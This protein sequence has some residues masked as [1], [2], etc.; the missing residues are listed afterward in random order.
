MEKKVQNIKSTNP[1]NES[2]NKQDTA[3]ILFLSIL[4]LFFWT[5]FG[6]LFLFIFFLP[7]WVTNWSIRSFIKIKQNRKVTGII[8]LIL[9]LLPPMISF[10]FILIYKTEILTFLKETFFQWGSFNLTLVFPL[11]EILLWSWIFFIP[12]ILVWF[13]IDWFISKQWIKITDEWKTNK[14][15]GI[16]N[17]STNW[18]NLVN[19]LKWFTVIDNLKKYE[20][21]KKN[22]NNINTNYFLGNEAINKLPVF[23]E[24][25]KMKQHTLIIGT[26]GSG[27]TTT[28][29]KLIRQ[30]KKTN[31]SV[32]II[33]GKG[34]NDLIDK[35]KNIDS[36]AFIWGIDQENKLNPFIEKDPIKILD[37]ILLLFEFSEQH[38]KN[39]AKGYL[40]KIIEFLLQQ[41]KELSF[42]TISKYFDQNI[43]L[44]DYKESG[45]DKEGYD[46]I[47]KY[48]QSDISGLKEQIETFAKSTSKTIGGKETVLSL[49]GSKRLCL[50][51]LDSYNYP[52][53]TKQ[54]AKLINQEIKASTKLKKPDDEVFIF[55]DEADI[56]AGNELVP[57]FNK[58]REFNVQLMIGIQTVKD[59][60]KV[61][62]FD[63]TDKI[64]G[65]IGNIIV[66]KVNDKYT[67]EYIA[68]TFGTKTIFSLS[69]QIDYES[70]YSQKGSV[71]EANEFIAHPQKLKDLLPG[72]AYVKL[73]TSEGNKYLNIKIKP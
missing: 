4:K 50:F 51:S 73:N 13:I 38:Y 22:K 37:K 44:K 26:T 64:F 67:A 40:L 55:M 6:F 60:Q 57:M 48:N 17:K 71:S 52:E 16:K 49:I 33:D 7:W 31:Q 59:L 18:T 53:L 10:V 70:G 66:Q 23:I 3:A 46:E 56:F 63:I 20:E 2:Q 34:S 28:A 29:L 9:G 14:E 41:N 61:G 5:T 32:I 72:E 15:L 69:K 54:I 1:I 11:H 36:N 62:E 8:Y 25:D 42:I 58:M 24:K 68:E 19:T 35:V 47:K 12:L 43:F 21:Y 30:I 45:G 65:N 27:K 39:Q